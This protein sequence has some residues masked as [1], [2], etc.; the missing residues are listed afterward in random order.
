VLIKDKK[1]KLRIRGT[2]SEAKR[3]RPLILFGSGG[4]LEFSL[5]QG[6]ASRKLDISK[7]EKIQ[8]K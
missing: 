5:N 8:V 7:G 3:G 6:N 4:F 1:F 2:Y